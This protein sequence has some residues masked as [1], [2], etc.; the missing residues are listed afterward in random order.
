MPHYFGI[1]EKLKESEFRRRYERTYV[2]KRAYT[3]AAAL[4]LDVEVFRRVRI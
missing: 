1:T 4:G 2:V 3:I